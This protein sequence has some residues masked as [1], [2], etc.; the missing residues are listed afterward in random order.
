MKAVSSWFSYLSQHNHV[1]VQELPAVLSVYLQECASGNAW[2]IELSECHVTHSNSWPEQRLMARAAGSGQNE[3]FYRHRS[4]SSSTDPS[5]VNLQGS[6]RFCS[7]ASPRDPAAN[8]DR[9]T[10]LKHRCYFQPVRWHREA[11]K[12]EKHCVNL[13]VWMVHLGTKTCD[14]G[15][16]LHL[17]GSSLG[18]MLWHHCAHLNCV[19]T[20]ERLL[21]SLRIDT[22]LF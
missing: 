8:T 5:A 15:A 4:V 1:S 6:A 10:S 9:N 13:G 18:S 2:H 21:S 22:T 19:L 14:F 17:R 16:V 20:I 3:G 7:L 11:M 12:D